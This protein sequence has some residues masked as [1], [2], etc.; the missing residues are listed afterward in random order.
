MGGGG[1]GGTH[2]PQAGCEHLMGVGFGFLEALP[3]K[4]LKF[5][6]I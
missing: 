6:V 5:Q 2:A 4:I 3:K 1:G